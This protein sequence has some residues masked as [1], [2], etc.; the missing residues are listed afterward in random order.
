[1]Q[2]DQRALAQQLIDG[3]AEH[4]LTVLLHGAVYRVD[5]GGLLGGGGTLSVVSSHLHLG[6]LVHGGRGRFLFEYSQAVNRQ[7]GFAENGRSFR[8]GSLN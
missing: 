3:V 8:T 2:I 4:V 7:Y 1:M 5:Y 6:H